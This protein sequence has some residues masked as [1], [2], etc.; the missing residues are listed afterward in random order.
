M[1]GQIN[2]KKTPISKAVQNNTAYEGKY[3]NPVQP[4]VM[5]A[6]PR[7]KSVPIAPG[8]NKGTGSNPSGEKRVINTE[9]QP[10]G[11]NAASGKSTFRAPRNESRGSVTDCG[12][13]PIG[14]SMGGKGNG[15]GNGNR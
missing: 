15:R 10:A 13:T 5:E 6:K 7:G 14:M 2:V 1:K 4:H 12:Y 3:V 11:R 9:G 8:I